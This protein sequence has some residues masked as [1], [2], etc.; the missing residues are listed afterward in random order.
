MPPLIFLPT[1]AVLLV[2]GAEGLPWSS[3]VLAA[4]GGYA[5]WTLCEYR[6]H[7]RVLHFE[8]ADGL[9]AQLQWTI[10]GVHHDHSNDARRLVLPPTFSLPLAAAF[11]ACFVGAFG[12]REGSAVC[13]G[14]FAGYLAYDMLHFT[15]HHTHPRNRL[16]KWRRELHM[17][18][19]F[20]D[21]DRGFGVSVPYWDMVSGTYSPRGRRRRRLP[22][23]LR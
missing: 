5:L 12:A 4:L 11:W 2:E 23:R 1:I 8:P 19:H 9:G 16:G 17:R 7:R 15:L 18:H 3:I 13:A 20:E 21:D 6:G 10:H 14:F 22:A